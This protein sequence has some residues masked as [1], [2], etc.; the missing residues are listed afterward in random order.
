MDASRKPKLSPTKEYL[1]DKVVRVRGLQG[2]YGIDHS[3]QLALDQELVNKQKDDYLHQLVYKERKY[4]EKENEPMSKILL[5]RLENNPQADLVT[6]LRELPQENVYDSAVYKQDHASM[7]KQG[8]CFDEWLKRKEGEKRL[9]SKLIKEAKLE[10]KQYYVYLAQQEEEARQTRI[11]GME[12]WLKDKRLQEAYRMAQ[13]RDTR[14]EQNVDQVAKSEVNAVDYK[15][16]LKRQM[17]REKTEKRHSKNLRQE[18]RQQ[19]RELE[20][21]RHIEASLD[22][23]HVF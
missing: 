16:W 15:Q 20:A 18:M 12:E 1:I 2:R 7:S 11:H 21:K 17:L 23:R 5:Q 4:D 22:Q 19:E 9:K 8:L 10:Q 14:T 6:T 13:A 3:E